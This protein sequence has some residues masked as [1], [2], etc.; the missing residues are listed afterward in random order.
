MHE[1][2]LQAT[3]ISGRPAD[4]PHPGDKAPSL[5]REEGEHM[6]ARAGMHMHVTAHDMHAHACIGKHRHA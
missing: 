4:A 1:P 2:S 3:C 6:H 5:L